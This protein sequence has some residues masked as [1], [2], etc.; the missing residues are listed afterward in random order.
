MKINNIHDLAEHFGTTAI[1][2]E[3]TLSNR[4]R[5]DI[6]VDKLPT[7]IRIGAFVGECNAEFCVLC[8]YPFESSAV[9]VFIDT[10]EHTCTAAY[11]EA[12]DDPVEMLMHMTDPG[13]I[14]TIED[15]GRVL[16]E[17]EAYGW[18]IDPQLTPEDILAISN[19]MDKEEDD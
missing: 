15:A 3:S 19:D 5:T 2:L 6:H 1:G 14:T 4:A 18:R 13:E 8:T 17:A 12:F 7:Y 16:S 9:D 11:D 10:I